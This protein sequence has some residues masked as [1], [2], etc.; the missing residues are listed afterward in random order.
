MSFENPN[1]KTS[2]TTGLC[3]REK[4]IEK[5]GE[6]KRERGREGE[7]ERERDTSVQCHDLETSNTTW[8]IEFL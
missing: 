1:K 7:R 5:E 2:D 3:K 8:R 6:R 4:G